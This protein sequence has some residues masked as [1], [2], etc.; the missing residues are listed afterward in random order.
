LPI[1]AD[2]LGFDAVMI[3]GMYA[4]FTGTLLLARPLVG[5]CLDQFGRKLFFA[6][7]FLFYCAAMMVFAGSS[8]M[9]DFYLAR[10]LQGIGASL[11]WVTARTM[12]ADIHLA[13]SRG[14]QMG[15]LTAISVRGSMMGAFYG[16]TLLGFL[17]L[18]QAWQLAFGGYAL[19]ALVAMVWAFT[20]VPETRP[21]DEIGEDKEQRPQIQL[22]KISGI[23]PLLLLVFVTAFASAL[24]EPIY[25]IFVKNKFDLG[26]PMLAT[27][28]LPAGLVFAVL[29]RYSGQWSDRW[30]REPVI[31][32]G[33]T[34]AGL[35]SIALPLW[36]AIWLIAGSYIFF[37]VGWAMAS[38]AIDA[39]AADIA[40]ERARGTVLGFKEAAMGAGAATGPLVGGFIFEY[41]S[42]K[43]A[44]AVNGALLVATAIV[45]LHLFGKKSGRSSI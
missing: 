18:E 41:W 15:V 14:E 13:E 17:A 23:Y 40:P 34:I 9:N 45:V 19:A 39:M 1:R 3:G 24:I 20:R 16:F 32:L 11:M 7:A 42:E 28:F 12:V 31:A 29:P 37:A 22:L 35:V 10:F 36:P 33:I 4:V 26:I 25:L 38:P 8:D 6:F 2:E 5:Y 44:F 43:M 30:G 27:I 21:V